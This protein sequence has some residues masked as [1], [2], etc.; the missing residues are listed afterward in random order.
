MM[1]SLGFERVVEVNRQRDRRGRMFQVEEIA[2]SKAG[3][4][5]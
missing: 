3:K 4:Q 2:H 1:A 5:E